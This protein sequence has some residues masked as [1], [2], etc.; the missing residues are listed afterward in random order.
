MT[1]QEVGMVVM[2]SFMLG[3]YIGW[4]LDHWG[5]RAAERDRLKEE[6]LDRRHIRKVVDK[7]WKRANKKVERETLD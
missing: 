2:F 7:A 4:K 1:G 6:E 3:L 5:T